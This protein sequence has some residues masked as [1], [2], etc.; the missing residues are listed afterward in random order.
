MQ[1]T[2]LAFLLVL[3]LS[4]F[5]GVALL[6]PASAA[7]W[8]KAE[9]DSASVR[10]PSDT[11][12]SPVVEATGR[13][14]GWGDLR[15]PVGMA[16]DV[17][18]FM[19]V[20]DAMAGKVF[21]YSPEGESVEFERPPDAAGF[22]PIDVAVQESFILVLDYSE[23]AVLRYDP[24]GSY[25]DV[26]LSFDVFDRMRPVSITAG[27][28]GRL[29]TTDVTHHTVVLWTPLLAPELVIGEFGK[30]AGSFSGP[31]KAAFLPDQRIVVVES[32]NKRLQIFSPS[33][34]FQ[35]VVTPPAGEAFV[36]ARSVCADEH[37]TI[38]V[39]D[40]G[41][42]RI[43]LFSPNGDYEGKVDSFGEKPISPAAVATGWDGGFYVA[44]L[45]SRSVLIYR[46]QYQR[47][48]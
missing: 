23:N 34:T 7:E 11:M 15:E 1:R 38:F 36:S 27:P 31:R 5:H 16:V 6:R 3:V 44:D 39:C 41:G 46:L 30:G 9:T 43:V 8:G 24:K 42:G 12:G 20:A 28:G 13:S 32:G 14:V 45:I 48:Q 22:Y 17:K 10:S 4:W 47:T 29:L 35:R 2:V 25:L 26:L 18:G 21:R 33:G 19:Y 40:A 37:G